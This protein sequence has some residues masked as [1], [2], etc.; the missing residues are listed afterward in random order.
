MSSILNPTECSDN[1]LVNTIPLESLGN[2]MQVTVYP[3]PFTEA[4]QIDVEI[5]TTQS[6]SL[7]I[8]IYGVDGKLFAEQ[9]FNNTNNK[10][11][12]SISTQNLPAGL[13]FLHL[14]NKTNHIVKKIVKI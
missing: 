10:T 1:I 8:K 12:L 7:T 3:N 2:D 14:A 4:L 5:G 6:A 13:Y 11:T 9:E